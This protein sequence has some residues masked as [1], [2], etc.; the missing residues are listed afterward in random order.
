MEYNGNL[1]G[2]LLKLLAETGVKRIYGV[3]GSAVIPLLDAVQ[4]QPEISFVAATTETSAAYMAAY[5]A[6]LTGNLG[7]CVATSGPGAAGLVNGL[8]D[9]FFEGDPVLAITGQVK[10]KE[11]GTRASQYFNQS[12]LFDP[13]TGFSAEVLDGQVGT[14]VFPRAISVALTERT[15]VQ[16][17]VPKDVFSQGVQVAQPPLYWY[18]LENLSGDTDRAA[19]LIDSFSRPLL[20]LGK[21]AI[22][23]ASEW[24]QIAESIGAAVIVAQEIKGLVSLDHP[25]N[26]G[27]I[28]ETYLPSLLK[29]ADGIILVGTA[30]FEQPFLPKVP[31]VQVTS[32][33]IN[34]DWSLPLAEPITGNLTFLAGALKRRLAGRS[35]QAW[36]AKIEASRR[37]LRRQ[38][39]QEAHRSSRP[40]HPS[41]L[42]SALSLHLSQDAIITLD[43]GSFIHW[44]DKSFWAKQQ[45][46]LASA[47]WRGIGA[48]LPAA[49]A[50]QLVYPD[51]Q[52]VAVVGDGGLLANP[53]ELL[54]AVKYRL[55]IVV[56]VVNTGSYDLEVQRMR[57]EGASLRGVDLPFW[58]LR[59]FAESCGALGLEV[60]ETSEIDTAITKALASSKPALINVAASIPELPNL[61]VN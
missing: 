55:P 24:L 15:A 59:L 54:T 45:T 8:A 9:A 12:S 56:V 11:V 39:T 32:R 7:V 49:V 5:E 60:R 51:R 37:D 57:K 40:V 53:G 31:T 21:E 44:F 42:M 6:R 47:Y 1:A 27:G 25:L 36:L 10:I 46:V 43:T 35:N 4:R 52:V 20:V 38:L 33:T 61:L 48:A 14:E 58:N 23:T 16:V 30:K 17:T 34:L 22:F 26:L 29:E 50:A 2:Y 19:A 18:P 28:G 3:A 41:K 13:V